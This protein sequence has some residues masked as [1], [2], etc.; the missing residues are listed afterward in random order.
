ME[1]IYGT[2]FGNLISIAVIINVNE[3]VSGLLGVDL[4]RKRKKVLYIPGI[5]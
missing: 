1:T 3:K 4:K 5:N 2:N